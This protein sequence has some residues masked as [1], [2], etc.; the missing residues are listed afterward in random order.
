L[1]QSQILGTFRGAA[2]V[3]KARDRSPVRVSMAL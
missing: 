1:V 2:V 3:S